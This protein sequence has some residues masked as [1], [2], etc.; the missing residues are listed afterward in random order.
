[1]GIIFRPGLNHIGTPQALAQ[2]GLWDGM[3][4]RV[5]FPQFPTALTNDKLDLSF[6]QWNRYDPPAS[7]CLRR[8]KGQP[9]R[10]EKGE[11]L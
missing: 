8:G 4:P 10:E 2:A 7:P 1:M 9:L 11:P 3:P 6:A 5:L